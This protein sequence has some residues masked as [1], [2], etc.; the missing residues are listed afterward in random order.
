MNKTPLNFIIAGQDTNN[1]LSPYIDDIKTCNDCTLILRYINDNELNYLIQNIDFILIPYENI[2]QSGVVELAIYCRKP[3]LLSNIPIFMDLIYK[4]PSFG[5]VL[6]YDE[7][8]SFFDV[9][10]SISQNVSSSYYYS[11]SDIERYHNME[12]FDDFIER[13]KDKLKD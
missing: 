9:I 5:Y 11:A 10:K 6:N 13:F 3:M 8:D 7:Y 12:L 1:F 2:S 4:Y